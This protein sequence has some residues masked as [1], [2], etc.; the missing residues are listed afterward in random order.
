MRCSG[1][2]AR[3]KNW[4]KVAPPP[5][6]A[7]QERQA[8]EGRP[9]DV[10]DAV[11]AAR[12]G[13]PV[14]QHDADDLAEAQRHDGEI[15]AAQAQHRK[16]EHDAERCRQQARE[17][18]RLPEAEPEPARD[19]REGIGADRVEGDVAEIEQ[20]GE[21][22]H[23]IEAPAEHDVDQHR[24]PEIDEIARRERQERQRDRERHEQR[25][26]EQRAV[27]PRP[28]E[29]R[30]HCCCARHARRAARRRAPRRTG[31]GRR[32]RRRRQGDP[33]EARMDRDALRRPD[34]PSRSPTERKGQCTSATE[35]RERRILERA[36][37]PRPP[38]HTFSTS[39]RPSRPVGRKISTRMSTPNTET[40]L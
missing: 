13:D 33:I 15:V 39:G 3:P 12:D 7:R 19:E 34:R 31:A 18:Q 17:R 9:R 20:S 28:G 29:A 25:A 11:G 32:R 40:S 8:E 30:A 16:A 2:N 1:L 36:A 24:G 5:G 35:A 4:L 26:E 38:H 10:G 22:D 21:P 37:S 27:T 14:E 23:D 6:R